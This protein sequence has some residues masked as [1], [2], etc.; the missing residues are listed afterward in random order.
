[1]TK[2][3]YNIK[4]LRSV[5][6]ISQQAFGE[7]FNLTRGNISSYEEFRAEP[8]IEVIVKIANY[9]SI[10]LEHFLTKK[11]S[12]N[13]ILNFSDYFNEEQHKNI[14]KNFAEIP[15]L[16]R[17][18]IQKIKE[19]TCDLSEVE[20]LNF[21]IYSSNNFIAIELSQDVAVPLNFLFNEPAI[22]FF[23]QVHID[24]LH[25]LNG[26]FGLFFHESELFIGHFQQKES[27]IELKL[28]DWKIK[29]IPEENK[30]SFWKLYA[31]FEKINPQ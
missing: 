21:P 18:A 8:K 5:K 27:E 6:N 19:G 22:L 25:T 15:F 16:H 31:K 4:K 17:D 12:V 30:G 14:L 29:K 2:I 9:F 28:N 26:N 10:P 23:E 3:G 20:T 13:E 11:L 7:L 1:M 24:N